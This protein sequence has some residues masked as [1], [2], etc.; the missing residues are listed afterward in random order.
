MAIK[1]IEQLR[2]FLATEMQKLA[3]GDKTPSEIS[4]V[5]AMTNIAG[6]MIQA[7]K[8]EVD[9]NRT[10]G[11]TPNIGFLNKEQR[12]KELDHGNNENL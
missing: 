11:A 4:A 7:A 10:V 2:D 3:D 9:Y 5:N 6:K 12:L 8:L 1:N